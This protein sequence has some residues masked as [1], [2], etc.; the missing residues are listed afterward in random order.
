MNAVWKYL[1]MA[2]VAVGLGITAQEA[3]AHGP[4][5]DE[6]SVNDAQSAQIW[7]YQ[8][9]LSRYDDPKVIVREKAKQRAAQRMARLDALRWYGMS[10][11]R[12]TAASTPYT[13]MYSPAWQ[14][15]GGRPFAW[16]HTRPTLVLV[17]GAYVQ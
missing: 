6:F 9:Q 16:F 4:D 8:Q 13:S 17:P 3:T 14:M 10:N 5:Q 12:P 1:A 11:S 2:A 7:F 15:P